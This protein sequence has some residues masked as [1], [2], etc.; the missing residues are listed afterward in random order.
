MKEQE[1]R[2]KEAEEEVKEV[3]ALITLTD[4]SAVKLKEAAERLREGDVDE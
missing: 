1:Q 2:G 3:G 4:E